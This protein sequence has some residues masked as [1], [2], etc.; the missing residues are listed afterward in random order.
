MDIGII[1]A[2]ISIAPTAKWVLTGN[3]YSLLEWQDTVI[4]KPTEDQI[5]A[6]IAS[7]SA[8][9]AANLYQ[10]NRASSYPKVE[11]QLDMLWHMMDQGIIPGKNSN[12]YNS[13]LAVKNNYPKP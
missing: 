5:N 4:P 13:L 11:D 10:R 1:Q 8:S 12:W 3:D 2:I 7:L 9:Y 6:E